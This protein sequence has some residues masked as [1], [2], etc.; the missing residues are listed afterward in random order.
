M[1]DN[2]GN[3]KK[4]LDKV[5]NAVDPGSAQGGAN[6]QLRV[7]RLKRQDSVEATLEKSGG[8]EAVDRAVRATFAALLKH[9]NISYTTEP[10]SNEGALA[11]TVVD[12]WKAALQ[13][14]RW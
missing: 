8:I 10:I 3:G 6:P 7:A 1:V 14:R 5:R 4:L 13:L 2:V 11:E 9:T 12:A